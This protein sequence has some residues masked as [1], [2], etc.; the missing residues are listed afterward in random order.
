MNHIHKPLF[1][2]LLSQ[3][4]RLDKISLIKRAE[5]KSGLKL[6]PEEAIFFAAKGIIK[7]RCCDK[8]DFTAF[9]TK[10]TKGLI[11]QCKTCRHQ[12][13]I[14]RGTY[15]SNMKMPYRVFLK[16]LEALC[17]NQRLSVRSLCE[18]GGLSPRPA[19]KN[20]ALILGAIKSAKSVVPNEVLKRLLVY[21]ESDKDPIKLERVPK[22]FSD[23][24][25]IEIRNLQQPYSVG[26]I[27]KKYNT[28]SKT[29]RKIQKR[30]YYASVIDRPI[31]CVEE[32][33][34]KESDEIKY[35]E[36]KHNKIIANT[37]REIL[38]SPKNEQPLDLI[39]IDGK[40]A[41]KLTEE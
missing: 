41:I 39:A 9:K 24:Q 36:K 6:S 2:N 30:E 12:A 38:S 14:T 1:T 29:I 28:D 20:R 27:A 7:C 35:F 17:D 32:T 31:N 21:K 22:K 5:K 8:S 10:Q 13:G 4:N 11:Y 26:E 25:I 40:W 37:P 23:D 33:E 18:I 15:L 3:L 16:I 34:V 19:Q